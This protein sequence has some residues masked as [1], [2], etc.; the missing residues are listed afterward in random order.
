MAIGPTG[1]IS[2]IPEVFSEKNLKQSVAQLYIA[3]RD[4]T[5]TLRL[6]ILQIQS[7]IKNL[8]VEDHERVFR[9][10]ITDIK[11]ELGDRLNAQ[12]MKQ[13]EE[14]LGLTKLEEPGGSGCCVIL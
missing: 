13:V 9:D 3:H 14:S 8:S 1:R 6:A 12:A 10:A 11:T 5:E 4:K 2:S 7:D